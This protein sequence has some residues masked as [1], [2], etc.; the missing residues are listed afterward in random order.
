MCAVATHIIAMNWKETFARLRRSV[1]VRIG[2][3]ILGMLFLLITPL[4]GPLPG[5]GGLITFAI[6]LGLILQ[7]SIW[8]RRRYVE[9][10]KAQPKAGSWADW[11]LRRQSP[12]RRAERDKQRDGGSD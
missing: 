2:L 12:K 9:F 6:G 8:A 4:V 10:K 5:P 7:N 11:G 1:P 3:L